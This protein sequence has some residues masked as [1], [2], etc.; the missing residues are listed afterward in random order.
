M[1][2]PEELFQAKKKKKQKHVKRNNN[3]I[4]WYD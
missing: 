4:K 3:K 1:K 2:N